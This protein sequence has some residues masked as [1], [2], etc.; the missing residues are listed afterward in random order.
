MF[1]F[2]QVS[3]QLC[4]MILR[5]ENAS[6]ML[7]HSCRTSLVSRST[8]VDSIM[9]VVCDDVLKENRCASQNVS[10]EASLSN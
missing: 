7:P 6:Y 1:L 3:V 8:L 4:E 5:Q 10:V 2:G 9:Q